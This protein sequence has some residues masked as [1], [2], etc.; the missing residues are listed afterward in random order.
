MAP[1]AHGPSLIAVFP[2]DFSRETCKADE[3]S[4]LLADASSKLPSPKGAALGGCATR[5]VTG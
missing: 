1:L 4:V 2:G 3:I 5:C